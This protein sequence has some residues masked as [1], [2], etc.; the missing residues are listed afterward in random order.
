MSLSDKYKALIDLARINNI[1]VNDSGN[2]LKLDGVVP[3]A[4]VKN[5]MWEIYQS[6]DPHFQHH[7][8][9]MNIKTAVTDGDKVKVVTQ[10][11]Q[12][13]IYQGPGTDQPVMGKAS[14]GDIIM[15]INKAH[16]QW[17]LVRDNDGEEG[18][19]HSQYLEPVQ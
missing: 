1:S 19:C 15:L 17:W 18:Y 3:D 10:G 12:L 13:N 9:V 14:K 4:G 8:L 11:S 16:D 5:K 2:V 6:M 7:D